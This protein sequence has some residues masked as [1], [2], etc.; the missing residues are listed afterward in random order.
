MNL[1][2]YIP[3]EEKK[4][5]P[6]QKEAIMEIID[7][8]EDYDNVILNAPV[9]SGKSLIS[10]V[11]ARHYKQMNLSSYLYTSTILLQEQYLR[12]FKGL[13][14]AKGRSNFDCIASDNEYT[15]DVGRCKQTNGYACDHG[16]TMIEG[17][18]LILKDESNPCLYWKQKM[19]AIL[20]PIS[21]LNY[22]YLLTDTMYLG[23]FPYRFMGVYDEGHNLEK[24]LMSSLQLE[25]SDYQ[26]K[27]DLN[28]GF[29]VMENIEDW[30]GQLEELG[31]QYKVLADAASNPQKQDRFKTRS[32]TLIATAKRL[33]DD[34]TNWVFN[35][36]RRFERWA[37]RQIH[38]ITFKPV[39]TYMY[40]DFLFMQSEKHLIMS[41]SILKPDIFADELNLDDYKYIEIP[42]IVPPSCRPIY[43]EY[44]GS[45]SQRNFDNNFPL[46]C[47]KIQQIADKHDEEKG[48]IHT[49]TYKISNAL[50]EHFGETDRYLFHTAES[51]EVVTEEFIE[52]DEPFILVS[53]YSYE[54]VDFPYDQG[55]WQ[56]IAKN[57]YPY[58]GDAQVKARET[59][60]GI[61]HGRDYGWCFRQV[62]LVLSQMYGR[63]NRAMDDYSV[64]Y[65]LDADINNAFGPSALVTDYFLE[66]LDGYNYTKQ[67]KLSDDAFDRTSKR[68]ERLRFLQTSILTAVQEENL[69][70]LEKLRKAYKALEGPSFKEVTPTVQSLLGS[71]ALIYI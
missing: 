67:F 37:G 62:A 7:S 43:R 51:R 28:C 40:M 50:K 23:H 24:E 30:A 69:N 47:A 68:S 2:E 59:V 48:I 66:A 14:T 34:P 49:F 18:G 8:F 54:G 70:T 55:R 1:E 39:E 10:Y 52:A 20:A 36:N 9:G 25:L 53:P 12:D 42:S 4:F 31:H 32:Q 63:T 38:T 61:K 58:L 33:I 22:K 35:N 27:N 71:G 19:D 11:L 41:G 60:D 26:L 57:P 46:L 56:I 16:V 29:E 64:T 13:K 5:R 6:H 21:I 17:V 15:C 45:M 44:V 65:L 3:F